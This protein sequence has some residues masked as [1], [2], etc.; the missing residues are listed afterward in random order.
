MSGG[1]FGPSAGYFEQQQRKRHS[2]STSSNWDSPHQQQ[3]QQ[4]QEIDLRL[5]LEEL[6][7]GLTKKLKVTRHVFDSAGGHPGQQPVQELLEVP[8]KPGWKEGEETC[9]QS[10]Q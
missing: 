7:S 4:Q 2:N 8:V 5:S 6:Y 9:F 1:G 10:R 3:Q